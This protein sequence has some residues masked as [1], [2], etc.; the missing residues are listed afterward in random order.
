MQSHSSR[1]ADERFN[2]L[3]ATLAAQ[4]NV[5]GPADLTPRQQFGSSAQLR[6]NNKIF[7]MLVGGRLVLKLPRQRV[8]ALVATDGGQRFE[9]GRGRVMHEWVCV[10]PD[11]ATNWLA[12]TEEA[13]RFVASR[14]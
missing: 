14:R 3:V 8:D 5:T 11:A 4:P 12:L 2:E 10:A 13:M 1:T 6:V 9:P 7:A